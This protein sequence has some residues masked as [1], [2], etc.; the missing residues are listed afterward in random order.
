MALKL[1][2]NYTFSGEVAIGGSISGWE[3]IGG[4][5][6]VTNSQIY[7]ANGDNPPTG[8]LVRSAETYKNGQVVARITNP[9]YFVA[10]ARYQ[11]TAPGGA[12]Y[13]AAWQGQELAIFRTDGVTPTRIGGCTLYTPPSGSGTNLVLRAI[14]T[15]GTHTDLYAELHRDSDSTAVYARVT[16]TGDTAGPQSAGRW[17][18]AASYSSYNRVGVYADAAETDPGTL[19]PGNTTLRYRSAGVNRLSADPATGLGGSESDQ[20]ERSTVSGSGYADLAGATSRT[21]NDATG[22]IAT[23]YYYRCRQTDSA[24]PGSP[25]YT[26]ELAV[27]VAAYDPVKLGVMGDSLFSYI[28]SPGIRTVPMLVQKFLVDTYNLDV[29]LV[30][31]AFPGTNAAIYWDAGTGT[32]LAAIAEFAADTTL[33]TTGVDAVLYEA[34]INDAL[35]SGGATASEYDAILGRV[36]ADLAGRG[37]QIL[38]INI[39][40]AHDA[41]RDPSLI[42]AFNVKQTARDN[43]TTVRALGQAAYAEFLANEPT[44]LDTDDLHHA[45]I[46]QE[47]WG[48]ALLGPEVAVAVGLADFTAPTIT[49]RSVNS[50]GTTLTLTADEAITVGSGGNGGFAMTASGGAVTLTYSAGSGSTSVTYMTSRTIDAA[51][52]L[53][54]AYTQ[55]GNGWEDAAGNDLANFSGASV[56]NNSTQDA[57][58]PGVPANLS[59][60]GGDTLAYLTWDAATGG[61]VAGYKLRRGGTVVYNGPLLAY[62]DTGR[63]N[64]VQLSYTVSAYDEVPNESA[65]SSAVLVTP[66]ISMPDVE[67]IAAAMWS[68]NDRTLTE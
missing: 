27:K 44:Y 34:G 16:V 64:G 39:P 49:A 19:T 40:Y 62:L 31:P 26:P 46:G 37:I 21:L 30:N 58:A 2:S 43:G 20:W 5:W 47:Y 8:F 53:T 18:V 17:G 42:Q 65:Q 23:T 63:T 13:Y 15:D 24:A 68:R 50:A 7:T 33:G 60:L 57:V 66:G 67:E 54:L 25:V 55:P 56:T 11:G 29:A 32:Y 28:K 59:A 41:A 1:V 22:T 51:E 10:V 14:S 9:V 6:G 52:T 61:D 45:K 12:C 3:N 38:L 48:T 36:A 35:L 4:A